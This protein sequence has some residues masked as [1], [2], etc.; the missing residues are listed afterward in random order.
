MTSTRQLT[1]IA[2]D[3][4]AIDGLTKGPRSGWT[5]NGSTLSHPTGINMRMSPTAIERITATIDA[6][7]PQTTERVSVVAFWKLPES[8]RASFE[9]VVV[10]D[11]VDACVRR[12]GGEPTSCAFDTTE[13]VEI[14]RS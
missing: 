1:C 4:L 13:V 12:T 3:N 9:S 8:E 14:F 2:P 7:T 10:D 6:H 11:S 5:W